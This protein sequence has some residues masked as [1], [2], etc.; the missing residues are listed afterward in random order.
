MKPLYATIYM[1]DDYIKFH[2]IRYNKT[3]QFI[4]G[5]FN[6][7][8]DIGGYP[9]IFGNLL[10]NK[11]IDSNVYVCDISSGISMDGTVSYISTGNLENSKLP[12]KSD[13]FDMVS[14]L[15]VIE[16][17]YNADNILQ[18][19]S[20]ILRPNGVLLLTTPNL[21][22][23]AN[24]LLILLGYYPISMSI[25]ILCEQLG[26]RDINII[27]KDHKGL[28]QSKFDYHVKAYTYESLK[29]LL[30][31]HN[32]DILRKK[33]VYCLESSNKLYDILNKIIELSIPSLSQV[34]LIKARIIK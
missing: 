1:K 31:V 19:I 6:N 34:I 8:L 32:F 7:I 9:G 11:F 25:S 26:R 24:R 33:Y 15:E 30:E 22:S 21:A 14:C 20:R 4:D 16:H 29:T 10:I 27:P 17:L 23:W 3:I 5:E 28:M 13:T 18:E 12:F 2:S